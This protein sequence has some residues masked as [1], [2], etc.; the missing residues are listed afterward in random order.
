[1]CGDSTIVDWCALDPDGISVETPDGLMELSA[2]PLCSG[3]EALHGAVLLEDSSF[4]SCVTYRLN[5]HGIHRQLQKQNAR[6]S[7]RIEPLTH[8]SPEEGYEA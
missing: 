1:M 5:L 8:P 4:G 3:V 6:K 2:L 7:L